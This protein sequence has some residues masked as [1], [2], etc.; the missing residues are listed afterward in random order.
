M[1]P[2]FSEEAIQGICGHPLRYFAFVNPPHIL[3]LAEI[4]ALETTSVISMTTKRVAF[5]E[6]H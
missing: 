6:W 4:A 2:A 5:L 1:F 3:Q